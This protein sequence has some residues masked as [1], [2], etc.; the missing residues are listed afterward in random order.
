MTRR[1]LN[2][3]TALSLL[4]CV[5][6]VV[7]SMRR[8]HPSAPAPDTRRDPWSWA[9]IAITKERGDVIAD[10]L[11]RFQKTEKRYPQSISEL[12]P[13][14]LDAVSPPAA[15]NG[16]WKYVARQ[17]APGFILSVTGDRIS[18]PELYR[19]EDTGWVLDDK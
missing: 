4:L 10:A 6:V 5:A 16:R 12:V 9:A 2:L 17:D 3:V 1:L 7:A 14:Y 8:T 11:E 15:G 19:S 13:A 18:D